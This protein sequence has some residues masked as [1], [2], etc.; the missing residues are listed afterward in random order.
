MIRAQE[1]YAQ[2]VS[3]KNSGPEAKAQPNL[4][5]KTLFMSMEEFGGGKSSLSF[6]H[7]FEA[8]TWLFINMKIAVYL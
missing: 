5:T 6:V 8:T 1:L 4:Y 7:K 3:Q 2:S